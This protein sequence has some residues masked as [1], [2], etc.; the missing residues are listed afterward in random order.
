MLNKSKKIS[1]YLSAAAAI[2][3]ANTAQAQLLYTDIDDTTVVFLRN[4]VMQ[5]FPSLAMRSVREKIWNYDP[6]KEIRNFK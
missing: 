4:F 3:G 1:S 5:Y 6:E 2:L